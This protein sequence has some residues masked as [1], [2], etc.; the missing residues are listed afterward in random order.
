MHYE[1]D[2]ADEDRGVLVVYFFLALE[3]RI[4]QRAGVWSFSRAGDA[5][6]VGVLVVVATS[7]CTSLAH[8]EFFILKPVARSI[9]SAVP[10][11]PLEMCCYRTF[12]R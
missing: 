6:S 1:F 5:V 7:R 3:E 9:V 8:M 10:P 12:K 4:A 11:I 2:E